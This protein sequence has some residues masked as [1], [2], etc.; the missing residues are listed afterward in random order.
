MK[1]ELRPIIPETCHS[2]FEGNVL[3]WTTGIKHVG[4]YIRNYDDIRHNWCYFIGRFNGLLA[5]YHDATHEVLMQ[6]SSLYCTM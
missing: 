3:E 5:R 6:L 1:F 2:K 4:H